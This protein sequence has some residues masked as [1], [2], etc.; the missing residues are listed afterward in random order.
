[1]VIAHLD[2]IRLVG[3]TPKS[4]HCEERNEERVKRR[5]NLGTHANPDCGS[6]LGSFAMT[7]RLAFFALCAVVPYNDARYHAP[8]WDCV[9]VS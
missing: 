9:H 3:E 6:R 2:A 1:M 5:G 4:R 7:G 8:A